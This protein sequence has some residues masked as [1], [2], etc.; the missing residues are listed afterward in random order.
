MRFAIA[1]HLATLGPT[2]SVNRLPPRTARSSL[3]RCHIPYSKTFQHIHYKIHFTM[4]TQGGPPNGDPIGYDAPSSTRD[5]VTLL[6]AAIPVT[7]APNTCLAEYA[8]IITIG[9]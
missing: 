5:S 6:L 2:D 4:R 7:G 9:N 1:R 8:T 3:T